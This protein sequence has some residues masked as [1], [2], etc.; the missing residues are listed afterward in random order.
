MVTNQKIRIPFEKHKYREKGNGESYEQH[1]FKRDFKK[2]MIKQENDSE[3]MRSIVPSKNE[4]GFTNL[5]VAE[6]NQ[7]INQVIQDSVDHVVS[8]TSLDTKSTTTKNK[9]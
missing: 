3:G 5:G 9:K 6:Y 8:I 1:L 7:Q 2:L 4:L